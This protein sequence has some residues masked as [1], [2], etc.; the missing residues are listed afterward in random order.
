MARN[1]EYEKEKETILKHNFLY[2]INCEYIC[3]TLVITGSGDLSKL[4]VRIADIYN[5]HD[6]K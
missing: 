2:N 1:S 6:D 4:L 3:Q 5:S